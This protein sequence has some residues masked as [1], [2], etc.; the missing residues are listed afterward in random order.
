MTRMCY[1]AGV[2][3]L[4]LT[5]RMMGGAAPQGTETRML[6]LQ[7]VDAPNG[8]RL[9]RSGFSHSRAISWHVFVSPGNDVALAFI[10]LFSLGFYGWP[11]KAEPGGETQ[12]MNNKNEKGESQG[13]RTSTEFD[14]GSFAI[15]LVATLVLVLLTYNPSGWSYAHWLQNSFSNDGL[16]PAHFVVGVIVL[17][18]CVILL[19]AT[20]RSMGTFGLILEALLFGGI[21]WMLIDFGILSINSVTAFTWVILVILSVM[22]AIGLSWSHVW[23]RLTGQFEVDDD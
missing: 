23:R 7:R 8:E 15:R 1:P 21:V 10:T 18:G 22:L 6:L 12:T 4:D 19:T 2:L 9:P 13:R 14:W 3:L 17:I 20:Q 5:M 11:E 16:G